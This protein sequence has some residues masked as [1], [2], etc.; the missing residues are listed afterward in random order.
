ME[1]RYANGKIYKL[2]CKDG[3]Y[4]IGSTISKLSFRLNNHKQASTKPNGSRAYEYINNIGWDNVVIELI[5]MFP[6]NSNSE[7]KQREDTYIQ[8][9]KQDANLLCLNLHRAYVSADERKENMKNYYNNNKE[10]IINQ[11]RDYVIENK[12][13]IKE[14]KAM[15]RQQKAEH[16]AKYNKE[17]VELNKE[18]VKERR[19]RY[20]Q[21][22]KEQITAK[23]LEYVKTHKEAANARKNAWQKAKYAAGKEERERLRSQR[24]AETAA[25]EKET[26]QCGCGGK[27]Q[28]FHKNRHFKSKMH[29]VWDSTI[30]GLSNPL[31]AE[32]LACQ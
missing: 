22:N 28:Q 32:E 13:R 6:C 31:D 12:E 7:L 2:Q 29:T 24:K 26:I 10:I 15:Y 14:Y 3:H 27:Y 25:R 20:Y 9:A 8:K 18:A 30:R 17:Y 4:Y 1:N 19:K 11:H 16:I 5:E 21:E 23:N